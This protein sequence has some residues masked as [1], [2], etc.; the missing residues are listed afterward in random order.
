MICS[1]VPPCLSPFRLAHKGLT[2]NLQLPRHTTLLALMF[3]AGST[4]LLTACAAPRGK[5][6]P[7]GND[8]ASGD[9]PVFQVSDAVAVSQLRE[10]AV[11]LLSRAAQSGTPE[12]RANAIEALIAA[13]GRLK[14]MLP[15]AFRDDNLGVRTVAA[16]AAGR[17]DARETIPHI[18][19][20]LSDPSPFVRAAAMYA[21]LKMGE[22]ADLT[23]LANMLRSDDPRL[24][25]HTAFVLGELGNRSAVGL[26]REAAG[27]SMN[28]L[29]P[30]Q[31]RIL[32][33]QFAEALVKLGA[34]DAIH[35]IR[36]ALLP[37]NAED[38]EPA[39]LACQILGQVRDE[40]CAY[41]LAALTMWREDQKTLYP[42]EMRLAA[43]AALAK[44]GNT[45]GSFIAEEYHASTFPVQRAQAAMVFGETRQQANLA[46]LS[47]MIQDPDPLVRIAAAAGVLKITER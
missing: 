29:D 32:Q 24:R 5:P 23:P 37:S 16:L 40:P 47:M 43:A 14:P 42:P 10:K 21:L 6:A 7:A 35:E 28:R 3:L 39:V 12:F 38:M 2:M 26:L 1:L 17:V 33:L 46:R 44:I 22:S 41:Q 9:R 15:L 27:S 30:V 19:P 34:N 45:R 4:M 31:S 36:A 20:L 13:P 8:T 11:D 25:A 18:R